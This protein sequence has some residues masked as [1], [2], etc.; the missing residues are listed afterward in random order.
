MFGYGTREAVLHAL[1][2]S[3]GRGFGSPVSA[4]ELVA[5]L[6]TVVPDAA[7]RVSP[8]AEHR[9]GS[10]TDSTVTLTPSRDATSPEVDLERAVVAAYSLGWCPDQP[11]GTAP[12]R[13]RLRFV[14]ATP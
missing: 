14:R 5:C 6:A 3:D 9:G 8:A 13:A 10:S 12:S 11:D 4:D 2:R 7:V 1:T